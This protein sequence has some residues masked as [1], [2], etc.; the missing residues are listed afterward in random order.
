MNFAKVYAAFMSLHNFGHFEVPSVTGA[1][2]LERVG[3]GWVFLMGSL[4]CR[5]NLSSLVV[6]GF[7]SEPRREPSENPAFLSP[8]L[9]CIGAPPGQYCEKQK[10]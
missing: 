9:L 7:F 8:F 4:S 5:L 2:L 6:R 3:D 10:A 1:W